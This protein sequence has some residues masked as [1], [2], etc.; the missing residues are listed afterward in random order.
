MRRWF[1]RGSDPDGTRAA[2]IVAIDRIRRDQSALDARIGAAFVD[3][4][5]LER[6][7]TDQCRLL[8]EAAAQ[9]RDAAAGARS[10]AERAARDGAEDAAAGYRQ[11]VDGFDAQAQVVAGTRAQLDRLATGAAA[12]LDRTRELLR[13]STAALDRA[14]RAE[15]ELLARLDRLERARVVAEARRRGRDG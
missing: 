12:D 15:V 11:A 9:I 8:D 14:L 7:V 2:A 6:A 5:V 1:G 4:V 3:A 13:E 10:A